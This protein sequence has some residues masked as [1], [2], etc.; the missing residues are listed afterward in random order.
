MKNRKP[1]VAIIGRPNVGKS[2]FFNNV[3]KQRI[4]IIEDIPGV[5]RDRIYADTSWLD[6]EFTLIDTGGIEPKSSDTL[7]QQMRNQAELAIETADLI[8][9]FVDGQQGVTPDDEDVAAM[10]RRSGKKV[11]LV[12]N[13]IDH[14]EQESLSYEFYSLGMDD[15]ITISA[16]NRL[17]FGDLLDK[18]IESFPDTTESEDSA[19]TI[20][21]AIA[22][23]PN[24]G[25][26]SLLNSIVSAERVIVSDIAGT[27]RDAIDTPFDFEGMHYNLIDTA[28]LRKKS[29]IA[30]NTVERYSVIRSL[31]AIRRADVVLLVVDALE[32]VGEQEA[33]IAGYIAEQGKAVLIVVNKW[34]LYEKDE[35]SVD[36][37]RQ[38]IYQKL[39]FL[40]F[41]P[42]LFV[43]AKT[44][45]RLTTILPK[46]YEVYSNASRR[47]PTGLLNDVFADAINAHEPPSQ[48]GR[49]PRFYY[50]TQVSTLPPTF[51]SFV[52]DPDYVHFSYLRYLENHL[53][54]SFSLS[55]T[56]IR[57][58][59]R[60]RKKE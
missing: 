31:S 24:V 52:N 49:R 12:V 27:T 37:F 16:A 55:G 10:L 18:I 51:V 39:Q 43:S 57:I 45:Q 54:R 35:H 15:M 5:T 30:D 56:P 50:T 46:V 4:S 32:G 1:L 3:L 34:D 19:D 38:D 33:R 60:K 28:G 22:G 59:L 17:G 8:L 41:A 7:W 40:D 2:S 9:F 6:H 29:K 26:S 42:V 36:H 53:R 11:I 23:K 47:V 58:I 48:K 21:V 44:N 13:K 25:K 14:I 20:S